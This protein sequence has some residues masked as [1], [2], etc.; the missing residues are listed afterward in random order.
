M[1]YCDISINLVVKQKISFKCHYSW[2]RLNL[3]FIL[4]DKVHINKVFPV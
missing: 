2:I 1:K 4:T 3:L